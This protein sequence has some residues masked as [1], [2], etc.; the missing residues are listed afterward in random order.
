MIYTE[1]I[2]VLTSGI[3][4]G[5]IGG[6]GDIENNNRVRCIGYIAT[7]Q[8]QSITL[9]ATS[10]TS[11][12]IVVDLLG[13]PDDSTTT[14]LFDIYWKS[15]G[16]EFDLTSYRNLAYVRVVLKYNDNS[17]LIPS[18]VASCTLECT[19]DYDW[20]VGAD[21]EVTNINF[22]PKT[23]YAMTAPYPKELW[24]LDDNGEI[25]T[26][27]LQPKEKLG[28]FANA[29]NLMQISIPRS[30]KKIGRY[31]FANTQLT[32]VTIASDCAYSSTSFPEGCVINFYPS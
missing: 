29:V 14:P 19:Y 20:Y 2:N 6:S 23:E 8:P 11:K 15:S 12:E 9:S 26:G 25:T 3:E 10:T 30:C 7:V 21:G 17:Q 18:E 5:S 27:A 4:Q 28:A 1:T 31:A 13:Y 16:F 32:S 24:R 22:P